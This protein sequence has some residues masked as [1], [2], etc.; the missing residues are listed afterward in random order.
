MLNEFFFGKI[1]IF[2][3]IIEVLND[4][5]NVHIPCLSSFLG[6]GQISSITIPKYSHYSNSNLTKQPGICNIHNCV[7]LRRLSQRLENPPLSQ[8]TQLPKF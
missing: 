5:K 6:P 7:Q 2:H 4:P 3:W 8:K 1:L